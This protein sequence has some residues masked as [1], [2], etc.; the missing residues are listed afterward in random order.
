MGNCFYGKN[1]IVK[2]K[3]CKVYFKK[4]YGGLS[5]RHSCRN[6]TYNNAVCMD[7]GKF[8]YSMKSHNCYHVEDNTFLCC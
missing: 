2:C 8:R 5:S 7:C 1:D 6:H 4:S 3:K